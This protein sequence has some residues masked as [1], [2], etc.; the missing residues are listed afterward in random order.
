MV[1]NQGLA[2]NSWFCT[3]PCWAKI[4]SKSWRRIWQE[5]ENTFGHQAF[6]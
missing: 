5:K 3:T 6:L 1:K 4:H 2:M